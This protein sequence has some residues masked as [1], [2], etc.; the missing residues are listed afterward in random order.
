MSA[1]AW[2]PWEM[3]SWPLTAPHQGCS[4]CAHCRT[5]RLLQ[6]DGCSGGNTEKHSLSHHPALLGPGYD[7]REESENLDGGGEGQAFR[8][9]G[10]EDLAQGMPHAPTAPE[11]TE[12]WQ[13]SERLWGY[14]KNDKAGNVKNG[15]TMQGGGL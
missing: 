8:S 14:L 7:F 3:S 10:R 2:L 12:D 13:I 15:I 9:Q 11:S 6:H 1:K 4:Y 5:H